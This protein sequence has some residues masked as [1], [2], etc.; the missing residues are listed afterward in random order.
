MKILLLILFFVLISCNIEII[1]ATNTLLWSE[2]FEQTDTKPDANTW[3]MDIGN[4]Q[5]INLPGWGCG[6]KQYYTETN[7]RIQNGFLTIRALKENKNGFSY[8]SSKVNK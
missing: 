2:E 3:T 8:T 6:Q 1:L 4:G 5:E 7:A